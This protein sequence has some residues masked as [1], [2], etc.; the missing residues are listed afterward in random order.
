MRVPLRASA[1]DCPLPKFGHCRQQ[2]STAV[3]SDGGD[4]ILFVVAIPAST[5]A[6]HGRPAPS[7]RHRQWC[8]PPPMGAA[9]GSRQVLGVGGVANISAQARATSESVVLLP[10]M[11]A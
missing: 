5:N 1:T 4:R 3:G 2:L 11:S 10:G 9:M 8:W 7:L 6:S